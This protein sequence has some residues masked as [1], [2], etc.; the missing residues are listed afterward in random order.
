[1]S[2]LTTWNTA[3]SVHDYFNEPRLYKTKHWHKAAVSDGGVLNHIYALLY[4]I[5]TA[6]PAFCILFMYKCIT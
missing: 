2:F 4:N 3:K 1:M 6:Y 5:R